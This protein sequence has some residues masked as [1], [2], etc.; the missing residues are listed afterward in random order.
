MVE[1]NNGSENYLRYGNHTG[2]CNSFTDPH[3]DVFNS[4]NQ[5]VFRIG[6]FAAVQKSSSYLESHMDPSVTYSTVVDAEI[7]GI[8]NIYRSNFYWFAAAAVVELVAIAVVIPT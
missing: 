5:L 7:E 2:A 8:H 3:R 4:L 1:V 6:A